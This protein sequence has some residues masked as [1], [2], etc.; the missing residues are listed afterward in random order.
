[1]T[2]AQATDLGATPRSRSGLV[3][4]LA[5]IFLACLPDAMLPPALRPLMVE[6]FGAKNV[7]HPDRKSVV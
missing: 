7:G 3:F 2:T 6:R 1:M 4:V 5:L